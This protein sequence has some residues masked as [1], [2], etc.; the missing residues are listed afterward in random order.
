MASPVAQLLQN[1]TE[2]IEANATATG[3]TAL[4][5]EEANVHKV[6]LTGNVTFSFTNVPEGGLTPLTI[7]LV[8]DATG[9]Y[10]TTWPSGLLWEGGT[11]PT[12][13]T[14]AASISIVTLFTDDAGT[15]WYAFLSG[16]D[17]S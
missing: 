13:V 9:G 3:A 14:T 4:N 17:M 10:T 12:L 2:V 5:I 16:S 6:T 11:E 15:T 7:I 8:Q 1:Y